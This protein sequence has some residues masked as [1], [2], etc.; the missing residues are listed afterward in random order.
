[1]RMTSLLLLVPTSLLAACGGE[2]SP[3]PTDVR[4]RIADDLGHVL[5]ATEAAS[6]QGGE[7]LQADAAFG[8]FDRFASQHAFKRTPIA[9][10]LTQRHAKPIDP[11]EESSADQI[12]EQLNTKLFTEANHVGDGIYKIPAD[13]A[14]TTEELDDHGSVTAQLDPECV[15]QWDKAE[16]RIR[17]A[18]TN[19]TLTLALQV[20]AKHDEPLELALTHTSLAVTLDLDETG[21]AVAA[22]API[23]G[24]QAPNA[25]LAGAVTGKLEVLGTASARATLSIDR[26]IEVKFADAG[27]SLDSADALRF[28]SAAS[29]VASIAFDGVA[30][31][32]A[33]AFDLGDTQVH[34]PGDVDFEEPA[35]DLDL[36]GVSITA[37]LATG[38]PVQ[39]TNLSLGERTTTLKVEGATAIAV[40]LNKTDG[41]ALTATMSF[42][43][44]T[45]EGTIEVS[46]KL[47]LAIAID[48]AVLGDEAPVYDVTR[49][50][51]TGG[52][53]AV[54]ESD[55]LEVLG[56]LAIETNPAEFGFAATA[57]QCVT[58]TSTEDTGT[59]QVYDAWSVGVCN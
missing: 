22:L 59:G 30:G 40:D 45:G 57:G 2:S 15:T 29:E 6:Q 31:T 55:Q 54:S 23:F 37:N 51:L 53:R 33:L 12:I 32:G 5:R 9:K 42:D 36:P 20:G 43:D 11:G 26:A 14:C 13:F 58:S 10:L 50:L 24:E 3:T 19:D 25:S 49:V 46:P 21:Q 18:E 41:R 17:T 52:L 27:V 44:A 34:I 38:Q 8:L 4:A 48:H 16:L 1:M 35:L 56:T 39:F 7:A 28:S 47:D